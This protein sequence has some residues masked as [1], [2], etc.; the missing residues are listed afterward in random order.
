MFWGQIE[1][2]F[3]FS[4]KTV[5]KKMRSSKLAEFRRIYFLENFDS[6]VKM[7]KDFLLINCE[8]LLFK[9]VYMYGI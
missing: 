9:G 5:I 1:P 8:E 7:T 2:S 3:S 4:L 6:G